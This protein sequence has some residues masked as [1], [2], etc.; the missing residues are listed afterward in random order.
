MSE[1][2]AAKFFAGVALAAFATGSAVAQEVDTSVDATSAE[3]PSGKVDEIIVTAQRRAQSLNS[4]PMSITAIGSD[5]LASQGINSTAD[6]VKMVPG[7]T[8]TQSQ[9]ATPVYTIRGVGFYESTLSASPAVS[10]NVDEVPLPFAILTQGAALDL[11]RVEVLKGPQGTLYGQ[12]ATGGAINYISAKPTQEFAAGMAANIG[13]FNAVDVSGFVSGP[14]S[15][16]LAVRLSG[17]VDS[18]GEWQKSYSRDDSL[19]AARRIA[20]RVLLVWNPT[21]TLEVTANVNAWRDKSDVQAPQLT[22]HTPYEPSNPVQ[23]V[24]D[25]PLAPK[26]ARAAD[27]SPDLPMRRDDRFLQ[28]SLRA[29]W[30]MSDDIRLTS[31]T[32]W[33]KFDTDATQDLDATPWR[34]LDSNTPGDIR[35]FYQELRLIGTSGDARWI[36]GANYSRDKASEEQVLQVEDISS[37]VIF[38]QFPNLTVSGAFT[39]QKISTVAAFANVEYDLTSQLTAQGGIRYT[40]NKRDF[41]GCGYDADGTSYLSFNHLTELF[42]GAPPVNPIPVG[43]CLTLDPQFQPG[44]VVDTLKEDN[45]SW[46]AGLT[47]TF[48]NRA[49]VYGNISRG[50][51]AGG[52]PTVPGS[53]YTNFLPAKQ[54]SLLAFEAGFKLPL[55]ERTLQLNGAGFYYDYSDKQIRGRER[56]AYFGLLEKLINVPESHIYGAEA[57][58]EWRPIDGLT[59]NL[60]GTWVHSRID[61]FTGMNGAG[62]EANFAGSAFPFT[63]KWQVLTDVQYKWALSGDWNASV[64]TNVN[65]NSATNSTFGDPEDLAINARTLVDLRAGIESEDGR[66]R[67]QLWGR[68]VFNKYYWNT[69]F[70]GDTVWRMTGRPA[71][72]GVSI[73]WRY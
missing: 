41:N 56:D 43:G 64:G 25:T 63:P 37:R 70:Q 44:L 48:D 24:I 45:I 60:A 30:D 13:R 66:L 68:N 9:V 38:P 51:K 3:A 39:N 23:H 18:G 59:A 22:K 58:L 65:Y 36:V 8:F 4:V 6:L 32:S 72:Y 49:I 17:R 61:K 73:G 55:A 14:L 40:R 15:D 20:G 69:T 53:S 47:Y 54:E 1:A 29:D 42:T 52:F 62:V 21:S 34:V 35:S 2:L 11:E 71:T 50:W 57:S 10:V 28:A 46:R 5:Q 27:W 16:T 12:N 31:V 33:L 19:G 26:N 67:L 7:L